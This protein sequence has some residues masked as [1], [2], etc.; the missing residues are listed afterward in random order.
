MNRTQFIRHMNRIAEGPKTYTEEE[1]N[2]LVAAKVE[3]SKKGFQTQLQQYQAEQ[4]AILDKHKATEAIASE[5]KEKL[6]NVGKREQTELQLIKQEHEKTSK[7][8][9]AYKTEAEKR[10]AELQNKYNS[11]VIQH[12]LTAVAA[13]ADIFNVEQ[14]TEIYGKN[15]VLTD[16]GSV[17]IK[18][19]GKDGKELLFK[20]SEFVDTLKADPKQ[21]N[22]F[23]NNVVNGLGG[24]NGNQG[25]GGG[26]GGPDFDSNPGEFIKQTRK[27]V[28]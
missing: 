20:P 22:L 13:S 10:N 19:K 3:E 27:A 14:F 23:K 16:D 9:T 6:D 4:K 5:L 18:Q 11:T 25:G 24:G 28:I 1:V 26:N 17:V 15:A 7:E 2:A 12:A 21:V 8:Y